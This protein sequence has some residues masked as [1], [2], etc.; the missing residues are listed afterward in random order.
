[1]TQPVPSSRIDSHG[2]DPILLPWTYILLLRSDSSFFSLLLCRG[3]TNMRIQRGM[4]DGGFTLSGLSH[5]G[6]RSR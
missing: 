2:N 6:F 1:M 5:T 3:L 4:N